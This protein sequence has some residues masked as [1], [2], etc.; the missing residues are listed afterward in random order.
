LTTDYAKR[1]EI[2]HHLWINYNDNE[3]FEEFIDLNDLGLPMAYFIHKGIVESTP[4]AEDLVNQSFQALLD[5]FEVEDK[6]F[7]SLQQILNTR[8]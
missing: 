2:L 7:K 6:G 4:M 5:M 8:A 1:S 3:D